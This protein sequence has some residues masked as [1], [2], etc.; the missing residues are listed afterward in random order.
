MSHNDNYRRKIFSATVTVLPSSGKGY[1]EGAC[2]LPR[3]NITRYKLN[4]L[5]H[6]RT[7]CAIW[8]IHAPVRPPSKISTAVKTTCE[9]NA[10]SK[11]FLGAIYNHGRLYSGY[12]VYWAP[13]VS[14]SAQISVRKD[15]NEALNSP[16]FSPHG[17][18]IA[19]FSCKFPSVW[20]E[21]SEL[22][23]TKAYGPFNR[24]DITVTHLTL[25]YKI[26]VHE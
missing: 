14:I 23:R 9:R 17:P 6:V 21:N 19:K 5:H 8:C 11:S 26:Q 3:K 25:Q 1:R 4:F 18:K 7:Q 20:T 2:P 16:I 12:E 24:T 22:L 15:G 10:P 13:F